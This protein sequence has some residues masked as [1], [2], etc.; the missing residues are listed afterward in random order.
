MDRILHSF[1]VAVKPTYINIT[2]WRALI[3]KLYKFVRNVDFVILDLLRRLVVTA[4]RTLLAIFETSSTNGNSDQTNVHV[5]M[6]SCIDD[7]FQSPPLLIV[8]LILT[9]PEIVEDRASS[10]GD[11]G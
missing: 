6:E 7:S 1:Y 9:V 10:N 3:N 4:T 2:Q 11:R 5:A 8:E